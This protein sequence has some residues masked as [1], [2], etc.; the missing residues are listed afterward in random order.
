MSFRSMVQTLVVTSKFTHFAG[1]K[2]FWPYLN[3]CMVPA[4]KLQFSYDLQ[5]VFIL[6]YL[7]PKSSMVPQLDEEKFVPKIFSLVNRHLAILLLLITNLQTFRIIQTNPFE[8]DKKDASALT[9]GWFCFIFVFAGKR[10]WVYWMF[11]IS[12][13]YKQEKGK[14]ALNWWSHNWFRWEYLPFY[15]CSTIHVLLRIWNGRFLMLPHSRQN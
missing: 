1:L 14:L 12:P 10:L 11:K 8:S 15:A 6:D 4:E 13:R 2:S 3:C 7:V 5:N 9:H